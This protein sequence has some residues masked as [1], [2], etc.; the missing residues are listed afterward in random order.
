V[1]FELE[2]MVNEIMYEKPA[3]P[4]EM[5]VRALAPRAPCDTAATVE[6]IG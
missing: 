3:N 4:Y 1:G 5:L 6:C 2:E